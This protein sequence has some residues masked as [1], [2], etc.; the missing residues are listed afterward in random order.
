MSSGEHKGLVPVMEQVLGGVKA[1]T[2]DARDLHA[3]L[4][5][6]K[7]FTD[8]AKQ[9]IA[10]LRLVPDR[11]YRG[12]VYH[13]EGINPQAGR[14]ATTYWFTLD[15]A[16]H[17]AMMANTERGFEVREYFLEC[18]RLARGAPAVAPRPEPGPLP[19]KPFDEWTLEEI[20]VNLA[21]AASYRHT[22][23]NAAA[24]W[25]LLRQ[26]FPKPPERLMPA[27]WQPDL[28]VS[29]P[30]PGAVTITVPYT[31]GGSH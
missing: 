18:E 27:W 22:F 13:L 15:A 20:G 17:I 28:D 11:D 19:V 9:Q 23:N 5:L 26:G 6:K 29:E 16:K 10:R 30:R 14:P 12:E 3:A 7:P 8:W 31:N 2:V 25:M 1:Q 24:G 21:V 4:G